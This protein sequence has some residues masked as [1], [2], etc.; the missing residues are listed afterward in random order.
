M[1]ILKKNLKKGHKKMTFQNKIMKMSPVVSQGLS[2][3]QL[4]LILT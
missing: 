1:I 2:K 4:P 3:L